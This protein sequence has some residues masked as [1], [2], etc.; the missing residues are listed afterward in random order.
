M[1]LLQ[2][3]NAISDSGYNIANSLRFQSASSQYLSRTPASAGNRKTWTW[4]GWVKRGLVASDITMFGAGTSGTNYVFIGFYGAGSNLLVQEYQ[5][6]NNINVQSAA[7]YRDPSA[8][9]HIVVA[10]DTT[11]ATAA[12]RVKVYV[13]GSEITYAAGSTYPS[14]NFDSLVDSTNAHA[15]GRRADAY[16]YLDGYLTE[17]NFVDGQA[18]TP[19]SFGETNT[20]T[21][22][23]V[24]KKYTGTYGTNGYYL[25][26][27]NGTSTT[28]LGSDSSG[29]GNN[30]TLTNFTRSAGASDCWMEDVP[31][32]NGSA[33][34]QPN[35][36]YCVINPLNYINGSAPSKANL[37]TANG[38]TSVETRAGGTLGMTAGKW[39]FEDTVGG[40]Y[41]N[42]QVGVHDALSALST[43][44]NYATYGFDGRIRNGTTDTAY[45]NTIAAGDTVGIAIDMDSGKIWFSKNGTWQ[46]SGDP[47]AG[48]N[49]AFTTLAGATVIPFFTTYN[50]G[51]GTTTHDYNG[52]QR[53]FAYTP[54]SG[55]KALCT[56]NL[57][58]STIVK[59]NQY[60][61]VNLYIGNSSTNTI[62]NAGGFSPDFVWI[63]SR[64]NAGQ[65][66][67]LFDTIRGTNNRLFSNTT[68]AQDT[69]ANTLT[70]FNSNGFTLGSQAGQND[71]TGSYVAW[72]W[73]A[74]SST[75]T[76]TDGTISSQ[77][78][79]NPTAGVS[80][81]T[82]TAT[83]GSYSVGHG[84]GIAPSMTIVKRRDSATGGSWWTW[85][86]GIGNNT[87]DYLE[88]NSTAAEGSVANMWG[89]VGRN[90]TVC[91]FNGTAS[92]VAGGTFVMYNFA[93]IAGF[94]KFGS[95]TGNGSTDGSFVYLGF[96]PKYVLMKR[97]NST[98][99]WETY[100]TSRDL[101]NPEGQALFPNL[102]SAESS[103]SPRIDLL[104][105]GF[106]LRTSGAGI[107]GSGDSYIYACFAENP[108]AQA[109]AR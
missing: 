70:S 82:F 12:N 26:F 6:A 48:T 73:D 10:V 50:N 81:A 106:K 29:N 9:Y 18:L 7:S 25:P 76:N 80:V 105:N 83:S 103:I 57:P 88:L 13:N 40:T 56:A 91:G 37:Y 92:T 64:S 3:S 84:L 20:L 99:D 52:G 71:N 34:T 2:N 30:W 85:H 32:G 36:N 101:Y 47:V 53:S 90:S 65:Y 39:Y 100:D 15:L 63:K 24:A 11:Q 98:G 35:S 33:G 62:V 21:G 87:T 23:W 22:Q 102:S 41:C 67:A 77:V 44:T 17:V 59:G 14:Q 68:D 109:N 55:F 60:M 38:G 58:A 66:H 45:G 79:A 49:A 16:G 5:G 61:D 28:T 104:S 31:S 42:F 96:R 74:G 72:Q 69:T 97:T 46:G 93:E 51:T 107:N 54:P 78:R 8:W 43:T 4:S 94:S 75:V 19:S 89:T 27:S 95:Y 108:F 1:S 86:I